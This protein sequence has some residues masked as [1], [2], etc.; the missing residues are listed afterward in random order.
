MPSL[1]EIVLSNALMVSLLAF[2][3]SLLGRV[4]K[5]AA[6]LHLLWTLVLV[7]LFI[8]PV[9][10][11][12]LP[13]LAVSPVTLHK[14]ETPSIVSESTL[15]KLEPNGS[16][17]H[18]DSAE[19][20]Q[21]A[22]QRNGEKQAELAT[23]P[24]TSLAFS[25][26]T[27][28][29]CTWVL[30]NLLFASKYGYRIVR[31]RKLLRGAMEP[32]DDVVEMVASLSQRMGLAKVPE[33]RMVSFK[34]TPLVWAIGSK[35][36]VVLPTQ[37][38]A[39]LSRDA[40]ETV[41]AHE[42]AHV[43]RKDHWV[44]M[45]ELAAK[46]LFWWHPVVWFAS[47]RLQAL[48]ETCCDRTVVDLA[49]QQARTYATALVDTL[50]FL[51]G[52]PLFAPP[53]ATAIC[54]TGSLARRIIMLNQ[55]TPSRL[56]ISSIGFVLAVAI[57]PLT[58]AFAEKAESNEPPRITGQVTNEEGEPLA[59]VLVRVAVP[60]TDMRFVYPGSDHKTFQS[61]TSKEGAM[62]SSWQE[63]RTLRQLRLMR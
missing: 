46:T 23:T 62:T 60:D 19:S 21:T 6:A 58:V 8:P 41:L 10:V 54:S 22:S 32:S 4:W 45:L 14:T 28:L 24:P 59:N 53:L 56:T 43:Q 11:A 36:L 30:G 35:P 9:V 42:L 20:S 16:Q 18:L 57:A 44:R 38:F 33:V 29:G 27:L 50:D 13:S 52:G 25:W 48:A 31:F 39:R 17:L 34:L 61:R 12:G 15:T 26:T 51:S 3:V 63:S 55:S 7:K 5:N 47:D 49:P 37:L 1:W 2:G 40:Q